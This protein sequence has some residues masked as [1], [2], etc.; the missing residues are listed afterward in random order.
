[1]SMKLEMSDIAKKRLSQWY[2]DEL[3]HRAVFRKGTAFGWLFGNFGQAAVTINR[4]VH[5]TRNAPE[6][7]DSNSGIAL[8]GHEL[9]HVEQ[10]L[11]MGWWHFLIRYAI[12]WRPAHVANGITHALEKPA[13]ERGDEILNALINNPVSNNP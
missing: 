5:L 2:D 3:L 8:L 12:G 9:L 1:M 11:H 7:F 6:D 10:Q 13:Y 4:T